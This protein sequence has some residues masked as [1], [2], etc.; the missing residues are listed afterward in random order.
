MQKQS[1]PSVVNSGADSAVDIP[2]IASVPLGL[3]SLNPYTIKLELLAYVYIVWP[4]L[5]VDDTRPDGIKY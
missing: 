2:L 1:D 5:E 4:M 3:L